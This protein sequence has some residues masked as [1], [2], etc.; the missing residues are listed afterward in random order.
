MLVSIRGVMN[1]KEPFNLKD[2]AVNGHDVMNK[3]NIPPS[4]KVGQILNGLFEQVIEDP[5][6]NNRDKLLGL[7]ES[8]NG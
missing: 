1:R 4:P 6:L 3:L 2:L 8:K 7:M 5:T